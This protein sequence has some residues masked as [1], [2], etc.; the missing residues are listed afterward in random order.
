MAQP[1]RGGEGFQP[2]E[3]GCHAGWGEQLSPLAALLGRDGQG[4]QHEAGG[5]GEVSLARS[6][7]AWLTVVPWA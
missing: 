6:D 2:W 3:P 5:Q 4:Q 1:G 7:G